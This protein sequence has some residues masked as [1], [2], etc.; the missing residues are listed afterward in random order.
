MCMY[1]VCLCVHTCMCVCMC[2]CEHGGAPGNHNISLFPGSL[3][4][5]GTLACVW[6]ASTNQQYLCPM[7]PP[8]SHEPGSHPLHS[9]PQRKKLEI[10]HINKLI[11]KK[12]KQN[13]V[14]FD[15][16]KD[17]KGLSCLQRYLF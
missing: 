5:Q 8:L 14:T 11:V 6:L 12:T 9:M 4:S 16:E 17:I 2:V 10:W 13:N 1:C 3:S 7:S 15:T